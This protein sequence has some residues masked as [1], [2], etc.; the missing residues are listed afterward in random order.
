[1]KTR[2]QKPKE[3]I[4]VEDRFAYLSDEESDTIDEDDEEWS[5]SKEYQIVHSQPLSMVNL[6][7]YIVVKYHF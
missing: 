5:P 6:L 7:F 4:D 2:R 3:V 1:M